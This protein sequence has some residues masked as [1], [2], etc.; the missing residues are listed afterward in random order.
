M[1]TQACARKMN[2]WVDRNKDDIEEKYEEMVRLEFA[3]F[4]RDCLD[5][6]VDDSGID[7]WDIGSTVSYFHD[8]LQD[9][10][11]FKPSKTLD[12]FVGDEFESACDDYGDAK[13]EQWKDER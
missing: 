13:Y 12:D 5:D 9:C 4:V 10:G 8:Y 1:I 2:K 11:P 3:D 7:I 6:F